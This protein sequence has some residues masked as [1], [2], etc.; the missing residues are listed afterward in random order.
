M[1]YLQ[2]GTSPQEIEFLLKHGVKYDKRTKKQLLAAYEY[3]E[4]P[5]RSEIEF[6]SKNIGIKFPE[7]YLNFLTIQ[8]GGKPDPSSVKIGN[9]EKSIQYLYAFKN[10]MESCTLDYAITIFNGRIPQGFIPIAHESSGSL[11]IMNCTV[12]GLGE[13]YFWDHNNEA[14]NSISPYFGNM[15]K[16]AQSF[17]EL[18]KIFM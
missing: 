10:P 4:K 15:K 17:T 16:I 18:E 13:I 2:L 9:K 8:N 6:Y 12:D 14:D 11:L 1:K 7:D 5:T 3:Q